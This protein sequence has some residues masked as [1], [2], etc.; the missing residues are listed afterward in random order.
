MLIQKFG[1]IKQPI[2]VQIMSVDSCSC[3]SVFKFCNALGTLK[4]TSGPFESFTFAS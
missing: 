1:L 3:V 2:V 4:S